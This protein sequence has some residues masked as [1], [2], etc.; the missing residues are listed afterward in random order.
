MDWEQYSDFVARRRAF[1]WPGYESYA[2]VGLDGEWVT[3]Y[4]LTCSNPKGPVL[5]TYNFLDAPTAG[6]E[7]STLTA[8]GY[9]PAMPFNRVL[10]LALSLS[11]LSRADI[12]VTHAFHLLARSRSERVPIKAI[13]ASFD[14][15]AV[16]EL[17]GRHVIALGQ[18]AARQCRR[19]GIDHLETPHLSARG[20][21]FAQRATLLAAALKTTCSSA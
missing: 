20:T 18:D 8:T 1:Y 4:H 13:D 11:G 15:I 17:V 9:L 5:L 3:P 19:H 10:D 6:R 21:S 12:Y 16:H 2:D 14:A 7:V